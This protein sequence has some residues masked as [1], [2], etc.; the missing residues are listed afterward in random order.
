MVADEN[1]RPLDVKAGKETFPRGASLFICQ[2][3]RGSVSDK[4]L[5]GSGFDISDFM[6]SVCGQDK[7]C[8]H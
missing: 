4:H 1:I 8:I 3:Q 6:G 2:S 7:C 5:A